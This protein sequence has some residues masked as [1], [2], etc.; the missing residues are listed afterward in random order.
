MWQGW[1]FEFVAI[2]VPFIVI[3]SQQ[4]GGKGWRRKVSGLVQKV[5]THGVE[6]L[7]LSWNS[8][9]PLPTDNTPRALNFVPEGSLFSYLNMHLLADS[10]GIWAFNS[11]SCQNKPIL[12]DSGL[13]DCQS[14]QLVLSL[15]QRDTSYIF[16]WKGTFPVTKSTGI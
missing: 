5:R 13:S 4:A 10:L 6:H 8:Q 11:L 3:F 9:I 7:L 15:F 16:T 14:S 12:L 2:C 1:K